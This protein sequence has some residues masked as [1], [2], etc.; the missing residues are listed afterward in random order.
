[1]FGLSPATLKKQLD[2]QLK[3]FIRSTTPEQLMAES[4]GP[5][6]GSVALQIIRGQQE[7]F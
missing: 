2:D 5:M 7:P 1:M 3:K 4:D 6:V